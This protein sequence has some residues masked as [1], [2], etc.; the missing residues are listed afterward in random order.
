MRNCLCSNPAQSSIRNG[1]RYPAFVIYR[2][3]HH[4]FNYTILVSPSRDPCSVPVHLEQTGAVAL[5]MSAA[6]DRRRIISVQDLL[7]HNPADSSSCRPP[8]N[9]SKP[10]SAAFSSPGMPYEHHTQQ[11]SHIPSPDLDSTCY[12]DLEVWQR[13]TGDIV[14]GKQVAESLPHTP[15]KPAISSSS[16]RRDCDISDDRQKPIRGPWRIEEDRLLIQLVELYGARQWSRIATHFP[17]RTGKQ[18]RERWMNQLNPDLKKKNWTAEE[19]RII[20]RAHASLGNKWS[21]IANLLP[22]R[23]DNSV[24]NRF[25]STLKRAMKERSVTTQTLDVEQ[26]V[27]ALHAKPFLVGHELQFGT[28]AILNDRGVYDV[29]GT[30]E[31]GTMEMR[32]TDYLGGPC[33]N[34]RT[35]SWAGM[36]LGITQGTSV[37]YTTGGSFEHS[38]CGRVHRETLS[39]WERLGYNRVNGRD[40]ASTIKTEGDELEYKDTSATICSVKE[41]GRG[42][43]GGQGYLGVQDL[44]HRGPREDLCS[45][46]DSPIGRRDGSPEKSIVK[47]RYK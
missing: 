19:D 45:I 39:P 23:T 10:S 6:A 24:K 28:E 11:I 41:R 29:Y 20:L 1:N 12:S 25:N 31:A 35:K 13:G 46:R 15:N 44:Q 43:F 36:G 27:Q 5:I 8:A 4:T 34:Q 14:S 2:Q 30:H 47:R 33:I 21:A 16:V 17:N 32:R 22:G 37:G 18:A 26:F 38:T 3:P 40:L 7:C 9:I 42:E